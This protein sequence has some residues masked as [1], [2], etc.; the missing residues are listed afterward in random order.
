MKKIIF[1]CIVKQER[2]QNSTLNI[3]LNT[4]ED[5]R[6]WTEE[7]KYK[8]QRKQKQNDRSPSLSVIP[9]NVIGLIH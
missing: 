8:T 5:S 1:K 9:L 6:R 3:L 4:R 7:K 2:N